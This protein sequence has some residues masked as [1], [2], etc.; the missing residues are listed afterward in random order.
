MTTDTIESGNKE[1]S[2]EDLNQLAAQASIVPASSS[3]ME[4]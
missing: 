3:K 4:R 1:D 2:A